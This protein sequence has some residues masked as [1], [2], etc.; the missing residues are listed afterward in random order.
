MTTFTTAELRQ[1]AIDAIEIANNGINLILDSSRNTSEAVLANSA[2][3]ANQIAIAQVF[4]TLYA[5]EVDSKP[6]SSI[7]PR[8]RPAPSRI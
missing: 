7:P 2:M 3:H 1:K 6:K 8:P 4:A 5:A